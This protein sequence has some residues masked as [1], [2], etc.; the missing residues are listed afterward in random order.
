MVRVPPDPCSATCRGDNA[1]GNGAGRRTPG[2]EAI[3]ADIRGVPGRLG[4]SLV[5]AT[6]AVETHFSCPFYVAGNPDQFLS[7]ET[8]RSDAEAVAATAGSTLAG[9][10]PGVDT[11]RV[12]PGIYRHGVIRGCEVIRFTRG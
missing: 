11:C 6:A 12:H 5:L 1:W 10:G 4:I 9:E 7:L 3:L 2:C 8:R